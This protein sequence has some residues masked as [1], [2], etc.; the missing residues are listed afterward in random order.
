[1]AKY[2]LAYH[3]GGMPET[4]EEQQRVMAAWGVWYGQLGNAVVDPGN[5]VG[6]AMRVGPDGG[7]TTVGGDD[8]ISGY[9]II[10]ADS[11]D[12]AVA[13]AQGNPILAAGGSIEV[14]ETFDVM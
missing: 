10:S 7:V 14:C 6:D 1:M 4:E 3:G 8:P 9:T 5:P 11:L 12:D 13:K 2:L